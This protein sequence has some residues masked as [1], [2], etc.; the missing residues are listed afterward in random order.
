[1]RHLL[2]SGQGFDAVLRVNDLFALGAMKALREA[3]CRIP[4]DVAVM[5][6]DDID[7][8]RHASPALTTVAPDKAGIGRT[9]V[10]LLLARI[11]G[12]RT[13]PPELVRPGFELLVRESTRR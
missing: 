13:G 5:G 4:D 10:T 9:A 11:N 7:E 1:M 2:A 12:T 6:F 8:G 3:G